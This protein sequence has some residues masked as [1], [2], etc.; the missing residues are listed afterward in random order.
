VLYRSHSLEQLIANAGC[1]KQ[2]KKTV[3]KKISKNHKNV[4]RAAREETTIYGSATLVLAVFCS[5]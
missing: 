3:M 2:D 1:V 4:R 5:A